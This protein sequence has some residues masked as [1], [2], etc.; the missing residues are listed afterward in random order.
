[1]VASNPRQQTIWTPRTQE[2]THGF[3]PREVLDHD[4][5]PNEDSDGLS[6]HGMQTPEDQASREHKTQ[7]SVEIKRWQNCCL[8]SLTLA[9]VQKRLMIL[10]V[11][12]LRWKTSNEFLNREQDW[13]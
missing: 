3:N 9:S 4:I 7:R 11:E 10:W 1:M 2:M 8:N 6:H 13:I 12:V 5:N